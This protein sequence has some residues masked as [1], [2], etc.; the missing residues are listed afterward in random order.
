MYFILAMFVYTYTNM[1][2]IEL[3]KHKF[4]VL[5]DNIVFHRAVVLDVPIAYFALVDN[6]YCLSTRDR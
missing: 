4:A 3:V 5:I 1:A 2:N 6:N